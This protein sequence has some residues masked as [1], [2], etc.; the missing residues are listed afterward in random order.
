[1]FVFGK[2]GVLCFLETPVLRFALSPY[3]RRIII[4]FYLFW[5]CQFESSYLNLNPDT[6]KGKLPTRHLGLPPAETVRFA[7]GFDR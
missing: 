2:F 6:F 3:Y 5:E 7:F 1:M 4:N